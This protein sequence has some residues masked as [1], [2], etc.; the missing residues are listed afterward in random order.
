MPQPSHLESLPWSLWNPLNLSHLC[1]VSKEWK[2][3]HPISQG[4]WQMILITLI[5][6]RWEMQPRWMQNTVLTTFIEDP[7][8]I[9]PRKRSRHLTQDPN[10]RPISV[11]DRICINTIFRPVSNLKVWW[12]SFTQS[13]FPIPIGWFFA[14]PEAELYEDPDHH[15]PGEVQRLSDSS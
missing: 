13:S 15:P 5:T 3:F 12:V 14:I 6:L 2:T 10:R 11:S 7:L 9:S 1:H 8:P 4:G